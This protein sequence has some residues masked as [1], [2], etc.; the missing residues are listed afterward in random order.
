MSAKRERDLMEMAI[1]QAR[2]SVPEG[3]HARPK[4]PAG[5]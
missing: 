4:V 1:E 5:P 3:G 2:K